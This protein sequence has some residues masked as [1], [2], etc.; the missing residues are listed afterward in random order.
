MNLVIWLNQTGFWGSGQ[1]AGITNTIMK[2]RRSRRFE[3]E[4]N[5]SNSTSSSS[6]T[7]REKLVAPARL[8]VTN[9]PGQLTSRLQATGRSRR[10]LND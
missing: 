5:V 6:E 2:P 3:L 7:A 1:G 10:G 9:S 4:A 8:V